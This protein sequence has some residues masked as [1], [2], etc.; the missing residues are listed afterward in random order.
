MKKLLTLS[1]ASLAS[2]SSLSDE[3]MTY[4]EQIVAP[5]ATTKETVDVDAIITEAVK[6]IHEE[7]W[8]ATDVADAIRSLRGLYLRDNSTKEGRVRWHGKVVTTSVDTNTLVRTTIHEDGE[9]FQDPAKVTTPLD[10]VLAANAKLP[11]PVMT[12]GIPARLAAARLRQRENAT[13]TNEVT[14]TVKAGQN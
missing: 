9:T 6:V 4:D 11:Q 7:G 1:L 3:W 2:L 5:P 12:N 13:T 8:T 10:A 14:V